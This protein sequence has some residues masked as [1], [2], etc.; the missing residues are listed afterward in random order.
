MTLAMNLGHLLTQA[1]QKF[2]HLPAMVH[3]TRSWSWLEVNRRVDS[4]ATSLR[5]LGIEKGD[6]ILIHAPNSPAYFECMWATFKL[7]A[8]FTP[9]NFRLAPPEVAYIARSSCAKAMIYDRTLAGAADAARNGAPSLQVLIS[10]DGPRKGE[11]SH[12]SLCTSEGGAFPECE[13]RGDDPLWFFYTSGTTGRSKAAVLTHGQMAFVVTSQLADV[14][15][16]TTEEDRSLVL[17]PLSHAAGVHA[18]AQVARGA[19]SVFPTSRR[20][21]A[22]EVWRLVQEHGITNMFAVPTMVKVLAEHETVDRY[23]HS[24]LRYLVYAGAPM[25]REDQKYA[26]QKLGPVLVQYYGMGEVTANITVLPARLHALDD[27]SM[28]VGSC[29]YARTGME[30]AILNDAGVPLSTG[31]TGEICVRGPA[32]FVGYHNDEAANAAAFRQGWFH[33]GDLGYR[34]EGG[35]VYLSGRASDMYISGG[36]NVYPREVEEA[37]LMH[38]AISEAAVFGLPHPVWGEAGV[39]VVV[40]KEQRVLTHEDVLDH[41]DGKL[42]RYKWPKQVIFRDS[43]PTSTYGKVLKRTMREALLR[44]GPIWTP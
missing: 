18:L 33:T 19:R 32:V 41:L 25:Y 31:Q 42:A 40:L 34:D 9:T 7:G 43:L 15:P 29:G 4:L 37:L 17:G 44:E 5:R 23:D 12:E 39:A 36:S 26:L 6:R 3:G 30:I 14:M 21:D 20:F 8:V 24:S 35:F 38:P 11:L 28:P 13:V 22:T 1:A 16:G 27:G 2:P 10:I